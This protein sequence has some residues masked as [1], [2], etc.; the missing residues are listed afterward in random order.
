MIGVKKPRVSKLKV[1]GRTRLKVPHVA[2]PK[3]GE[4]KAPST[5]SI[6]KDLFK[7]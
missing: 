6:L 1:K 3:I 4:G 2:T 7:K 5:A